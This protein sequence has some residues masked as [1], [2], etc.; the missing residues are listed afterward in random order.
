MFSTVGDVIFF[1]KKDALPSARMWESCIFLLLSQISMQRDVLEKRRTIRIAPPTKQKNIIRIE[2][3]TQ[4]LSVMRCDDVFPP[5]DTPPEY[6]EFFFFIHFFISISSGQTYN[7]SRY[8]HSPPL[9]EDESSLA[10]R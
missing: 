9:R 3:K 10:T 4:L 6:D 8:P 1:F 2:K 5:V 7:N